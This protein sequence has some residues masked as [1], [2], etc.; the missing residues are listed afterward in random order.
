MM[1]MMMKKKEKKER[2]SIVHTCLSE[3]K[4][5]KSKLSGEN[6]RHKTH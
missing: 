6:N 5:S 2:K 4:E 1:M 3:K